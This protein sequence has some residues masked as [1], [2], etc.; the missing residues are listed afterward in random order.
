LAWNANYKQN[1]VVRLEFTGPN[2]GARTTGRLMA[3]ATANLMRRGVAAAQAGQINGLNTAIRSAADHRH[4][5]TKRDKAHLGG[6]QTCATR[7][8][9]CTSLQIYILIC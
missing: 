3:V 2:V 7:C 1:D 6:S 4:L 8:T 9:T 5:P